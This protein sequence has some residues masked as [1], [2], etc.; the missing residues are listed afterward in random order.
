MFH[1]VLLV[2]ESYFSTISIV[3]FTFYLKIRLSGSE[4]CR[5]CFLKLWNDAQMWEF[6]Y[7][8]HSPFSIVIN[9]FS[10]MIIERK[11]KQ[12]T[13]EIR[14]LK[15]NVFPF[16]FQDCTNS[17]FLPS[18]VLPFFTHSIFVRIICINIYS[19]MSIEL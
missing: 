4:I 14:I 11:N 8:N 17:L 2:F 9:P 13:N 15:A 10:I 16:Q 18:C 7:Q 19:W 6:G 5:F 1:C 3:C 12:K